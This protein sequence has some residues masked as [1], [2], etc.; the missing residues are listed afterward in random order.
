MNITNNINIVRP[1]NREI[2][3]FAALPTDVRNAGNSSKK[4]GRSTLKTRQTKLTKLVNRINESTAN[5]LYRVC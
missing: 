4:E 2:Y 3:V 5:S 1:K